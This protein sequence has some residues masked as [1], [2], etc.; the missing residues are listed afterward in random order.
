MVISLIVAMSLNRVI[1]KQNKLPWHLPADLQK[2]KKHTLGHHLVMGS[3]TFRS[4]GRILPNRISIVVSTKMDRSV[5]G[6]HV[7]SS[8]E[9]AIHLAK[10]Q[11]ESELFIIGGGTI[12]HQT[13]PIA[14]RI[15]LTKVHAIL[16]GDT[17]FPVLG[18][19]WVQR[20][21]R[22]FKADAK[23]PYDYD[24]IVLEKEGKK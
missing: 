9:A 19:E 21:M 16:S 15:Y 12:Y 18:K 5:V 2:F 14:H 20:L 3:H 11:G 4:I 8:I 23:N 13:L 1:G 17:Y 24:F 10:A 22:S 7:V 6:Y